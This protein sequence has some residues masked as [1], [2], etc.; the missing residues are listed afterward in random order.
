MV[1]LSHFPNQMKRRKTGE[2]LHAHAHSNGKF[3]V[4]RIFFSVLPGSVNRLFHI[5][6]TVVPRSVDHQPCSDVI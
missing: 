2:K 6:T 4:N 1:W 5:R 3:R